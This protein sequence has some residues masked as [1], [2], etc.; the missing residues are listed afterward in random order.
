MVTK[1]QSKRKMTR[2]VGLMLAF[3]MMGLVVPRVLAQG[4]KA[5]DEQFLKIITEQ[6]E[7]LKLLELGDY[8][9][10]MDK[11]Q[12]AGD[13]LK[14]IIDKL[15]PK[16]NQEDKIRESSANLQALK[17]DIYKAW[18]LKL[19]KKV[20]DDIA[21]DTTA[22]ATPE[23]TAAEAEQSDLEE[24]QKKLQIE[25]KVIYSFTHLLIWFSPCFR[26]MC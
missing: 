20:E 10:A 22:V 6:E 2:V 25:H 8:E 9:K 3:C 15:E 5:G 26:S 24:T 23:Q 12:S 21:A 16:S 7:A 4:A 19:A 17:G 11:C 1:L 18:G 14:G 13:V